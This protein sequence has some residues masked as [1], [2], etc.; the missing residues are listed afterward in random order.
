MKKENMQ[1]VLKIT[2]KHMSKL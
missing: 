1:M 2:T